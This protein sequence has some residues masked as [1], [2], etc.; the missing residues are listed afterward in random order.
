M[1]H[2]VVL[3]ASH[4]V[5]VTSHFVHHSFHVDVVACNL[6][7]SFVITSLCFLGFSISP[8]G[9]KYTCLYIIDQFNND[10]SK[11]LLIICKDTSTQPL[12]SIKV[13]IDIVS[14]HAHLSSRNC[15]I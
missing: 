13:F 14:A 1:N 11:L 9:L 3:V 5:L 10:S 4:L 2:H 12:G 8:L 15:I 7:H 6:V